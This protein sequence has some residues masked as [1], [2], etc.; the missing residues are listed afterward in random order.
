MWAAQ[1]TYRRVWGQASLGNI[2]YVYALKSILV[3]SET[4]NIVL[5][6]PTITGRV[7]P[8]SDPPASYTSERER[9]RKRKREGSIAVQEI[10]CIHMKTIHCS[11]TTM[12]AKV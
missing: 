11:Y 9:E 7:W 2:F 3:H 12:S 6:E 1:P 8:F 10:H 4:N 5:L